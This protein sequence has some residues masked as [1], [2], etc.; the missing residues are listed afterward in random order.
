MIFLL[1]KIAP[2][3]F[4]CYPN[5][6]HNELNVQTNGFLED[7]HFEILDSFGKTVYQEKLNLSKLN[8]N[9]LI[10]ISRL[11]SG[12]YLIKFFDSYHT[13]YSDLYT[14]KKSFC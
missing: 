5:P 13:K 12:I 14:N 2:Q 1:K 8:N 10:D 7:V 11:S 9:N 3:D 4:K 6:A